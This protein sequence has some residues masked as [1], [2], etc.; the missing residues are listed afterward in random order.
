M[1]VF[2][3][4][5]PNF[6]FEER[7][8]DIYCGTIIWSSRTSTSQQ[9]LLDNP[10]WLVVTAGS[11][12]SIWVMH[13]AHSREPTTYTNTY[14]RTFSALGGGVAHCVGSNSILAAP[15]RAVTLNWIYMCCMMHSAYH[16]RA[17]LLALCLW[18]EHNNHSRQS[19]DTSWASL[20]TGLNCIGPCGTSFGS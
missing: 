11:G 5:N 14:S 18:G 6:P 15:R 7:H 12:I 10:A 9:M 2:L 20:K 8:A 1:H 16:N 19:Y 13:S 3:I 17:I 4:K